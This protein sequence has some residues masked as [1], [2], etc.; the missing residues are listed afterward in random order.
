MEFYK[1]IEVFTNIISGSVK[2]RRIQ[3]NYMPSAAD[4]IRNIERANEIRESSWTSIIN[5]CNGVL[6]DKYNVFF[7]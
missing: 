6:P 2:T 5:M 7:K 3:D 4:N 1:K